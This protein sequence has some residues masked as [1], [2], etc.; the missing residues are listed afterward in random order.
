MQILAHLDILPILCYSTG[1][2]LAGVSKDTEVYKMIK[3]F[4]AVAQVAVLVIC[5]GLVAGGTAIFCNLAELA[6]WSGAYYTSGVMLIV[7]AGGLVFFGLA[8]PL[9]VVDDAIRTRRARAEKRLTTAYRAG[10]QDERQRQNK[11]ARERKL[12]NFLQS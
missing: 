10:V 7:L 1:I 5:A 12:L 4:R 3:F 11:E 6:E 9:A 8:V 2:I